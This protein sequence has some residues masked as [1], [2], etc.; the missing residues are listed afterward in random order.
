MVGPAGIPKM[1]SGDKWLPDRFKNPLSAA[2]A[3]FRVFK[4][5]W[6]T[7]VTPGSVIRGL[8]PMGERLAQRYAGA[9]FRSAGLS[10]EET[11][12]FSDYMY[13]ILTQRGSGE[14][15]L[16]LLLHPFAYAKKCWAERLETIRVPTTFVYGAHDHGFFSASM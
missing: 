6:L 10:E 9:R 13:Q 5:L 2:G 4:G 1:P 16:N 15:A 8:G 14:F 11:K 12:N 7:G 3:A